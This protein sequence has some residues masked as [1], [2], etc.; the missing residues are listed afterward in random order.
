MQVRLRHARENALCSSSS[1]LREGEEKKKS[2]KVEIT[3]ELQEESSCREEIKKGTSY[4]MVKPSNLGLYKF[5]TLR[6]SFSSSHTP[7]HTH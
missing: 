7:S 5:E 4:V 6:N 1:G 2:K 3:S